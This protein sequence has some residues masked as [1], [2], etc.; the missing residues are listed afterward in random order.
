M[1]LS[2]EIKA[3]DQR[4]LKL[5][6]QSLNDYKT[7]KISLVGLGSLLQALISCLQGVNNSLKENFFALCGGLVIIGD[8]MVFDNRIDKFSDV[9]E[10]VYI[11]KRIE[12]L[13]CLIKPTIVESDFI[14]V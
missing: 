10:K 1:I 11:E 6:L 4:Q 7:G 3:Y 8:L 14:E 12:D 2:D 9:E 5:I 13:I